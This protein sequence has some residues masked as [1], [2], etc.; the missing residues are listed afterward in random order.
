[1]SIPAAP[2]ALALF[3]VGCIALLPRLTTRGTR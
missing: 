1:M 2:T 3:M